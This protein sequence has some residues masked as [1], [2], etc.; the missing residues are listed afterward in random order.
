MGTL[1]QDLWDLFVYLFYFV[2]GSEA[3]PYG[4]FG[5]PMFGIYCLYRVIRKIIKGGKVFE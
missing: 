2:F 1:I 5:Y 4:L 3:R